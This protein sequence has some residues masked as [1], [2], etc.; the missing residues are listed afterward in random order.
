MAIKA[1]VFDWGGTLTPWHIVDLEA[2]WFNYAKVYAPNDAAALAKALNQAEQSRWSHQFATEGDTGTGALEAMF[3]ELGIDTSSARHLEA[4]RTYLSGWDPHTY[5]Y[6]DALAL[7]EELRGRGIKTAV[8]SNTMWPRYHHEEILRRDGILHLFDHCYFTS[9]TRTAKPHRSV[10]SDVLYALDVEAAETAFV[11]DRLFD[12]I[13]GAQ[14]VGMKGIWLPHSTIPASQ[15]SE[16]E[17]VPDAVI[18]SLS[19]ILNVIA[20][21]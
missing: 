6:P 12:D 8:L 9:E 16:L 20:E 11:G 13:H 3:V 10:F 1:V 2:L 17:I 4:L 5:T 14:Q 21:W 7:L 15:S 19:D 18:Q